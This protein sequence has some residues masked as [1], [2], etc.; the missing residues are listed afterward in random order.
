[1]STLRRFAGQ[2]AIYGI[3]T[4]A[5]RV[6]NFFLTPLYVVV[7]PVSQ[8]A[9]FSELYSYAGI[10]AAVLSFGMETTYFRFLT[11]ENQNPEVYNDSAFTLFLTSAFFALIACFSLT[12]VNNLLQRGVAYGM[13]DYP[14]FILLFLAFLVLD[15]LN[16]IPFARLR[17]EGRSVR[18]AVLRSGNV[19]IFILLN[20]FFIFILPPIARMHNAA[21]HLALAIYRPRWIGYVFVSNLIASAVTFLLLLPEI[22]RFRFKLNFTLLKQ[23]LAY[24]WPILIAN[25]SF[26]INENLDKIY[27]K[28]LLPPGEKLVQLGIYSACCKLAIFL[29]L[30]IQAF[31]LGAEPFFF[32]HASN[33]NAPKTYALIMKYFVIMISVIFLGI[34]CNIELLK[35]FIPNRQM[36]QGLRVVP[37]I[38]LGY[39]CLGIYMNLSVWYK[40]SD[41]TKYGFYISGIGAVITI[42]LNPLLIPWIGF[43]GSAWT[44]FAAYLVMMLL[45][46][47]WGQRNYPIPYDLASSLSVLL[48]AVFLMMV[49]FIGFKRN[50]W[51][52]EAIFIV[53]SAFIFMRE[54]T[55][56]LRMILGND[57]SR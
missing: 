55:E 56:L 38:L 14:A 27:L 1:M 42:V 43:M 52:G 57:A 46:Y 25:I 45:S 8:Y 47:F 6:L 2:T 29:N 24:S 26:V 32:S 35:Y 11:R 31:R 10:I 12:S 37:L 49:S 20:L 16:V 28:N 18:Y 48:L 36:W 13:V 9:V 22:T 17:A 4:I 5:A 53:F 3:T 34:V 21:G 33:P 7:Y 39:V 44:T 50:I 15:N 54:K 51:I 40:L 41:Q 30:F 19:A 23:M